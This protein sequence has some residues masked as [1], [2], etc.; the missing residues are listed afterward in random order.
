MMRIR[1]YIFLA[2]L[3]MVAGAASA[4]DA[5]LY[6]PGGREHTVRGRFWESNFGRQYSAPAAP[7]FEEEGRAPLA[8]AVSEGKLRLTQSDVVQFAVRNNADINV[9]RYAPYAAY[10]NIERSRARFN[11]SHMLSTSFNRLDNPSPNLLSGGFSLAQKTG[12]FDYTFRKPYMTGTDLEINFG[13]RRFDTNSQFFLYNPSITSNLSVNV[14]HR[15]LR[16]A[17]R[18]QN[19]APTRIARNNVAVSEHEFAR[20]VME[21]V[22]N[23]Q[24]V[25]WDL[26]LAQENLKVR[27]QSHDLAKFTLEQNKERAE[28]GTIASLDVVQAEAEVATRLE[29]VIVAEYGVKRL[30]DQVKTL[31]RAQEEPEV[32]A[33]EIEALDPLDALP[34]LRTDAEEA[35]RLALKNRPEMSALE[36]ELTNRGL[37]TERARNRLRPTVDLVAVYSQNGLGGH[38]IEALVA[39]DNPLGFVRTGRI[40][41]GGLKDS[42][43]QLFKGRYLGYTVR[44]DMTFPLGNSEARADAAQGLIAERQV[45]SRIKAAVQRIGLEVREAWRQVQM[46]RERIEAIRAAVRFAEK[47]LEGEEVKYGVG[48]ST[49][50][51]VLEAQRDLVETRLLEVRAQVDYLKSLVALDRATGMT[52]KNNRIELSDA[53]HTDRAYGHESH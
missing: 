20:R 30:S 53:L 6:A 40:L 17:G 39:P 32:T 27:K 42:L 38:L 44:L 35:T 16:G 21:I 47:K 15:L 12:L 34:P 22:A 26:A 24:G 10:W 45:R 9:E 25:Y 48:A 1:V 46:N 18:E 49:T 14:R 19:M 11:P 28:A 33:A 3:L 36:L 37:D 51:L 41:P 4:Q 23:V 13:S 2:A 31:I 29:Q 8:K 50:R 5:S 7:S 43:S 52:L